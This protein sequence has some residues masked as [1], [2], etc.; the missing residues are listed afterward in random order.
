MTVRELVCR[1][2]RSGWIKQWSERLTQL[3]STGGA[4][5]RL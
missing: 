1:R 4:L 3:N 5:W 2:I